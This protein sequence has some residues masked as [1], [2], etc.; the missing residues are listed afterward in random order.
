MHPY[1]LTRR[2]RAS[3]NKSGRN[4]FKVE[5]TEQEHCRRRR[6]KGKAGTDTSLSV[7]PLCHSD[8]LARAVDQEV[9]PLPKAAYDTMTQKRLR[10]ILEEQGLPSTGDKVA[11][12]ARH[13]R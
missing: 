13:S 3:R 9:E 10:K 6:E 8:V 1:L 12:S 7:R 4:Y 2:A 5:A 11:M